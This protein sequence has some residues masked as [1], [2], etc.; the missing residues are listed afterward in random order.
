MMNLN[1]TYVQGIALC[2]ALF[3]C[4]AF[5][6][7]VDVAKSL[8][9]EVES[10]CIP[11]NGKM[12]MMRQPDG[13]VIQLLRQPHDNSVLTAY[14]PWVGGI[15]PSNE[16]QLI[17][18]LTDPNFSG[19]KTEFCFLNGHLRF[20][21]VGEKDYEFNPSAYATPTNAI[22]SLWPSRE[23][24]KPP[25]PSEWDVWNGTNR[26]RWFARNPNHSALLIAEAAIVLLGIGLF[27]GSWWV[28]VPGLTLGLAFLHP[29]LRTESRAGLLAF[30][31]GFLALLLIRFRKGIGWRFA[32]VLLILLT[33][34]AVVIPRL[35]VSEGIVARFAT[36]KV[37]MFEG[38][39]M[40][41]WR[42]FPRMMAAAPLGWG[43]WQSGP[44]YNSWFEK[45]DRMHMTGDL[46][47]DH[48]SR[49]AEGGFVLG[50]LYV[51]VW[52]F[53]LLHSLV[54]AWKGGSPIPL[55]VWLTYFVA[56]IFNPMNFWGRSFYFPLA[57]SC[58]LFLRRGR[59]LIL[60]SLIGSGTLTVLV[61]ASLA[62]IASRAP[63]QDI[64]LRASWLGHQVVAGK[65]EAQVWVVEDGFVLDGNY[66]GFPGREIR[67]FYQAHPDAEA[68][69][70]VRD[71]SHLPSHM[72]TLVVV[73][74]ACEPYFDLP[75]DRR[76]DAECVVFLSP[77]LKYDKI[78]EQ[79]GKLKD[80]HIVVGEFAARLEGGCADAPESVHV[81]P[82]AELYI[83]GWLD[84][85]IARKDKE[86][87]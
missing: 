4:D 41:M 33:A 23:E 74:K 84:S 47:N 45:P 44:A 76:P 30:L 2:V 71:L 37:E 49:L 79:T 31:I 57:V 6:F 87:E 62:I 52:S 60:K 8:R 15:R 59:P 83:P 56:C 61:L 54:F 40:H 26:L 66:F 77:P 9:H 73:G 43:L 1:P 42:E 14:Y 19:E 46:F 5:A 58:L 81:V 29:L 21:S 10:T 75:H 11:I 38:K 64:P 36:A 51:F 35:K 32:V 50:G 48:L 3:V 68:L 27:F 86:D 80:V 18:V 69:G 63:Q 72:R 65:G 24:M 34:V 13:W 25:D 67:E 28:R 12:F 70:L 16:G 20:M 53:V 82:G 39:R 22:A 55:A 17:N 7:G 85:V 78:L